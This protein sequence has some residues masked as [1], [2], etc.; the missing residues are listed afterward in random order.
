MKLADRE[1]AEG[2]RV[3]IGHRIFHS[4]G[5]ERIS[6]RYSAEYRNADGQQGS[7]SLGTS[8]KSRALRLALEIQQRL[9][10]KGRAS[11]R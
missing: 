1:R 6:R 4:N 8:N 7:E 2:T 3:T 11:S 10:A 5:K 9:S